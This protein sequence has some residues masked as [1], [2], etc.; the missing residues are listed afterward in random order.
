MKKI[1]KI[2]FVS[3]IVLFLFDS[4]STS[5]E[6]I[7]DTDISNKIASVETIYGCTNSINSLQLIEPANYL[8]IEDKATYDLKVIGTCHPEI[9][10]NKYNLIIGNVLTENK[11][12]S[13][14]YKLYGSCEPNFYKL[15]VTVTKDKGQVPI[16][17]SVYHILV[18]KEVQF[19]FFKVFFATSQN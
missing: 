17:S 1:M 14:K 8:I 15:V 7:C 11:I 16:D 5:N 13:L 9:D 19:E 2:Y 6:K 3:L 10:F 4:C 18:P 12:S